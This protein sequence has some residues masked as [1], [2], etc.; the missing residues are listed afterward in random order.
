MLLNL[1]YFISICYK[2]L[3]LGVHEFLLGFNLILLIILLVL[4]KLYFWNWCIWVNKIVLF[5][6][7]RMLIYLNPWYTLW[8]FDGKTFFYEILRV[9]TDINRKLQLSGIFN[10]FEYLLIA[11]SFIR[12]VSKKHLIINYSNWPYISNHSI[13]LSIKHFRCHRD[14]C[15]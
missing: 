11:I 13:F 8:W 9:C 2:L 6:D 7:K 4:F 5:C 3:F 1:L 15:S 10:L 12:I 14:P